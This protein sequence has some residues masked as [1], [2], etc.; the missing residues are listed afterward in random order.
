MSFQARIPK[1]ICHQIVPNLFVGGQAA[2]QFA[3]HLKIDCI[4]SIGAKSK[5]IEQFENF[6][7]GLRDDKT[8]DIQKELEEIVGIIAEQLNRNRRVLVHCKAGINRSPSFVL[9]F[10]CKACSFSIE[11]GME[12]IVSKR[13]I[14]KFSMKEEVERWLRSTGCTGAVCENV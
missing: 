5:S 2:T 10:I 12:F 9:A 6:H 3:A 11:E 8:L 14:C 4:I 13:N 7:F 1:N